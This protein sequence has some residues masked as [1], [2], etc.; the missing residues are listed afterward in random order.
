[1]QWAVMLNYFLHHFPLMC[2]GEVIIGDV[3]E[4]VKTPFG[5]Q[6]VHGMQESY[7]SAGKRNYVPRG[8]QVGGAPCL[9]LCLYL[10]VVGGGGSS[11][12]S[13]CEP[14]ASRQS[15]IWKQNDVYCEV[16]SSQDFCRNN[17]SFPYFKLVWP[18][19]SHCSV[20]NIQL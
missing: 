16:S 4:T 8:M 5:R 11:H 6:M 2:L 7:L 19:R 10:P 20:E 12:G 13:L 1:M 15:L 18:L 3:C 9:G 14:R 17:V